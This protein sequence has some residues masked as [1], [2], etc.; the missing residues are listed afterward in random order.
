MKRKW[1][2]K[3]GGGICEIK[4]V[5]PESAAEEPLQANFINKVINSTTETV[6][7][8]EKSET[9]TAATANQTEKSIPKKKMKKT[10][11]KKKLAENG[12]TLL[13]V[14]KGHITITKNGAVGGGLIENETELNPKGYWI[15]GTTSSYRVVVE[16]EV[17][18]DLTLDNVSITC[19]VYDC[20]TV[21]HAYVTIT[22]FGS[23]F[24][25][26]KDKR[27]EGETAGCAIG[28][29]GM[30]G[31]LTIRCQKSGEEGHRCDS[32]CGSLDAKGHDTDITA[33]GSTCR[34]LYSGVE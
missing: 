6:T 18:T 31:E 14:S 30:D 12:Q 25:D 29:D 8:E 10:A 7:S 33:I 23:N 34:G 20:I 26:C 17:K 22:L 1:L 13:D 2:E 32:S 27:S 16:K 15:T 3:P 24:L 5:P 11:G 21:S 9:T 4:E 28:K 19:T